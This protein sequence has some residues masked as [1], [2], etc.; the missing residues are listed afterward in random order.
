MAH[1]KDGLITAA[2]SDDVR[3]VF[4]SVGTW[5]AVLRDAIRKLF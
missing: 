5:E 1:V 3:G 2:G 4:P